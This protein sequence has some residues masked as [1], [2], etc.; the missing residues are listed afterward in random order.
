MIT[1]TSNITITHPTNVMTL[2]NAANITT[3]TTYQA[4]RTDAS[5]VLRQDTLTSNV[6]MGNLSNVTHAYPLVTNPNFV[7]SI[8]VRNSAKKGRHLHINNPNANTIL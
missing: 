6:V 8:P 3:T 5:F 7:T 2:A 1:T 4:P